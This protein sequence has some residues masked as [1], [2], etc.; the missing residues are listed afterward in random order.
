[1]PQAG[2]KPVAGD[3]EIEPI[4]SRMVEL[5][6]AYRSQTLPQRAQGL[7]TATAT[8]SCLETMEEP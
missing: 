5:F 6:P 3:P 4:F 1:M 7:D 8:Q 2:Q